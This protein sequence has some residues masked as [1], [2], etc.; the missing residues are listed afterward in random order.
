MPSLKTKK[1]RRYSFPKSYEKRQAKS[2]NTFINNPNRN[3]RKLQGLSNEINY[4]NKKKSFKPYISNYSLKSKERSLSN[5]ENN[6]RNRNNRNITRRRTRSLM[7]IANINSLYRNI[8]PEKVGEGAFGIVSRPPAKCDRFRSEKERIDYQDK[9]FKNKK[10]ISKLTEYMSAEKEIEVGNVVKKII[11][12]WK[13]YYCFIEFECPAPEYV[14][15]QVGPDDFLDTYAI[16]PYCG[17]TLQSILDNR[18]RISFYQS[19]CL[20]ESV[21]KLVK[22][23]QLLHSKQIYHQDIHSENVLYS[24]EDKNIRFID[25][26]SSINLQ[27]IK[28]IKGARWELD[29]SIISAKKEDYENLI[30]HIIIPVLQFVWRKI[31]RHYRDLKEQNKRIDSSLHEC[32]TMTGRYLSM[33][34]EKVEDD[35]YPEYRQ[36]DAYMQFTKEVSDYYAQYIEQFIK[37]YDEKIKCKFL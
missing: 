11:P 2:L 18:H 16:A 33:M 24:L 21:K 37:N 27:E 10:Y 17:I 5:I 26:G 34:P 7:S 31:R 9:Y 25:F 14:F 28:R 29:Y 3:T 12:K 4:L 20:I 8:R 22:G 15:E 36:Y 19:C 1:H 30:F 23:L 35:R 6:R 13:D 32:L